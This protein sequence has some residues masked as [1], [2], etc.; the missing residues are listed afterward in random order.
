MKE[1]KIC[2]ETFLH[3]KLKNGFLRLEIW[4]C[5]A[6]ENWEIVELIMFETRFAT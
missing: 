5:C 6:M 4:D 1:T 2:I 3:N